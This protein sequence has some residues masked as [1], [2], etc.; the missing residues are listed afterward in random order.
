M[1]NKLSILQ[2][3]C[4]GLRAKFESLKILIE[5][6][7]PICIALQETMLGQNKLCPREYSFYHNKPEVNHRHGGSA[8]LLRKDVVHAKIP[9]QT[10]LQAVAVKI[11]AKRN[12]TICSICLQMIELTN[13]LKMSLTT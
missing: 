11:F 7:F 13:I 9:L 3:N 1:D 5:E 6:H 10:D 8:L 2:W 4:Q 12:Y